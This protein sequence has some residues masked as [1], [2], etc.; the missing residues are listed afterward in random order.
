MSVSYTTVAALRMRHRD[1][2]HVS[3]TGERLRSSWR[4]LST[5]SLT[6]FFFFLFLVTAI[7]SSELTIHLGITPYS[8][9]Q[10]SE[11]SCLWP[12]LLRARFLFYFT[13]L[14]HNNAYLPPFMRPPLCPHYLR[15][16]RALPAV[17]LV[18]CDGS[19]HFVHPAVSCT[20]TVLWRCWRTVAAVAW[21][22]RLLLRP[23]AL[24]AVH[25]THAAGFDAR[26]RRLHHTCAL[27][28]ATPPRYSRRP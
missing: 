21:P 28:L 9:P 27:A 16:S 20:A 18:C 5:H 8:Q 1:N 10:L 15:A 19:W 22:R 4:T 17:S 14:R 6:F 26:A 25:A 23:L 13:I 11:S 12:I 2:L 24:L 7:C 3:R